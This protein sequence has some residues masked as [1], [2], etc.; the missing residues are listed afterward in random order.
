M[1]IKAIKGDFTICKVCDYS[2]VDFTTEYVFT[3]KTDEELSLVCQT[4]S[5]PT[6]VTECSSGWRMMRIEGKLDFSL[7]GIL[8]HVSTV[9]AQSGI[10][11]FAISTFNTDYILVKRENFP[12]ALDALSINGYEIVVTEKK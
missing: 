6:N 5:T 4:E 11:L 7:I 1:K 9:L 2:Q 12:R 8:S 3:G 10:G